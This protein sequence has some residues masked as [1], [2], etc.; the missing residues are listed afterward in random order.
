MRFE[1]TGIDQLTVIVIERSADPR[2]TFGRTFC[3]EAFAAAGLEA[4]FVQASTSVT[5]RRGTIRGM[6]F[7]R[8]PAAETKL[9]RCVRGAIHDVVADL[10]PHSPTFLRWQAFRL[11]AL[12]DRML[13]IPPGCAH[14][15]QTLCDDC[16]VLYQ[17][18]VPY[19]PGAADGFRFD[20]PACAISWPL[21]PEMISPNDLAWPPI[22]G[23]TAP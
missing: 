6:H 22:A 9:V 15:F 4:D 14:G 1:P 17:M 12:E 10:R 2:G 13:Y 7:Q 19:T 11:G 8:P 16:E 23:R 5:L 21:P 3:R 20:D 18:S